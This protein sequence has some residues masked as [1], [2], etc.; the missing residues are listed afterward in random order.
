MTLL[1]RAGT[2]NIR[3]GVP[4]DGRHDSPH[5]ELIDALRQADLD[6]L[7]LQE[8]PFEGDNQSDLLGSIARKTDLRYV[9][10]FPLS[11]STFYPDK[12]SGVA[13]ASRGPHTVISQVLLPNPRL[14]SNHTGRRWTSW[15]KGMITVRL[16]IGGLTLGMSSLHGYPFHEFGRR[17]EEQVFGRIWHELANVINQ[18]SDGVVVVA[19]D[20]NTE[21]RDLITEPVVRHS[22]ISSIDGITTHAGRSVDDILHDTHLARRRIQVLPNFSDHAFCRVEFTQGE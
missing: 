21:R 12:R 6:V 19:G 3:E 9:S 22:L 8:V 11:P 4:A 7:A 13:I 2:W 5:A 16:E 10:G 14:R 1:I 20:F 15:D 17:A 18:I